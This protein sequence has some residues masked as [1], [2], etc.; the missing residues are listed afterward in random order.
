[1]LCFVISKSMISCYRKVNS[2]FVCVFYMFPQGHDDEA[3]VLEH[4]PREPRIA[5]SA[6]HDGNVIIWD[7][8]SGTKIKTFFNMVIS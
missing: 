7:I 4:S 2:S 3:F 8:I 6:G 1:M 5:L